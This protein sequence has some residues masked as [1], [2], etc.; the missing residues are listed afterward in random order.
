MAAHMYRLLLDAP[1]GLG[2]LR[3]GV[4]AL[5]RLRSDS[6]VW[7]FEQDCSEMMTDLKA[8]LARLPF[9]SAKIETRDVEIVGASRSCCARLKS[10]RASHG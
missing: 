7:R 8:L 3:D 6:E 10:A 2:V 4:E 5:A 1:H 9:F